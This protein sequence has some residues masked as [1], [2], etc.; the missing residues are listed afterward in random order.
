MSDIIKNH[1]VDDELQTV[2]REHE[3]GLS[4]KLVMAMPELNCVAIVLLNTQVPANAPYFLHKY[5]PFTLISDN[6]EE[7][8]KM[9]WGVNKIER[10]TLDQMFQWLP[11]PK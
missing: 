4:Q 9:C 8:G 10:A 5:F 11:N 6:E 7:N 3:M 2:R 1:Y